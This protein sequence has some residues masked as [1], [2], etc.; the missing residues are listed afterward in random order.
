MRISDWSSDVCSSDLGKFDA[1]K[2]E[3]TDLESQESRAQFLDDAERRQTGTVVSGSE[4]FANIESRVSLLS[5]L[6]A[7]ME[8]RALN[9]AEAEVHAELERR[10]GKAQNGGILVPLAAFEQRANTTPPASD[11]VVPDH[12]ADQDIGPPPASLPVKNLGV[13]TLS[14]LFGNVSLTKAG[15]DLSVR[16]V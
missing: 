3:I 15:T 9:G 6:R 5:V 8:G 1:L 2:A 10:H 12:R 14:C 16:W 11:R 13:R 4:S 7:G